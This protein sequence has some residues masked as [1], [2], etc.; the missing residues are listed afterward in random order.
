MFSRYLLVAT[1][2]FALGWIAPPA[3]AQT[4]STAAQSAPANFQ[5]LVKDIQRMLTELG[6]RP[7]KIDGKM[8]DRTRQAIRRYQSNTGLIVDGHPIPDDAALRVALHSPAFYIG[9]LGSRRTQGVRSQ[10]LREK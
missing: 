5:D 2:I 10:R 8:G 6:Y 4:G 9:S 3:P 7:G 1:L